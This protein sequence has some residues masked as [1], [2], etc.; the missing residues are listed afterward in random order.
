MLYEVITRLGHR[1]DAEFVGQD[2]PTGTVLRYRLVHVSEPGEGPVREKKSSN[3]QPSRNSL[4]TGSPARKNSG[5]S[6]E[7]RNNFV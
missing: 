1:L 2:L 7:S 3:T 5:G 6:P 4:P